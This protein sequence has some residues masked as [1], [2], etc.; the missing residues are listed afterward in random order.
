MTLPT[1]N[2]LGVVVGRFQVPR[3]H[4]GHK[5]LL[6]LVFARHKRVLVLLACPAWQGGNKDPLDYFTRKVMILEAYPNAFISYIQDEQSDER[7]STRVDSTI[8]ELFPFGDVTLYGGRDGFTRFYSGQFPTV[9]T[10]EDPSIEQE[11][12]TQLRERAAALPIAAEAFRTGVIYNAA[13][14]PNFPIQCV[15]AA[16]IRREP[17]RNSQILLIQK[18]NETYWR[19]PGGHLDGNDISLEAAVNREA[20]EETGVEVGKPVYITSE[21]G[22]P[23]WRA[24]KGGIAVSSALFYLPYIYGAPRSGDD[25]AKIDWFH[26]ETLTED[27]M[28]PCHKSFLKKLQSWYFEEKHFEQEIT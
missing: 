7:W 11:T 21:C 14:I 17:N 6:D 10:M 3:L 23:D 25:A 16:I 4:A 26:L 9:E 2:E 27:D 8:R 18:S 13:N 28:E 24:L 22:I 20:R 15:D 19:F 1:A 12:G 5:R